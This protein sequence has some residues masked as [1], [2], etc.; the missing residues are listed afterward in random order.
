MLLDLESEA[1]RLHVRPK[2]LA[3]LVAIEAGVLARDLV[4]RRVQVH[5]VN[6]R[7]I[8]PLADLIV[9]VVVGGGDLERP[10][11]KVHLHI[12]IRNDGYP[13]VGHRHEGLLAHQVLVALVVRVHAHGRVAQDGLGPGRG[14]CE[15]VVGAVAIGEAV[16][17]VVE[18]ALLLLGVH[19][20]V[21]H[22]WW[23]G[24]A[25][26]LSVTASRGIPNRHS[27]SAFRIGIQDADCISRLRLVAMR[28]RRF[29]GWETS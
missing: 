21:A 26:R 10:R 14:D 28:A 7:Q 23:G 24:G 12:V 17:E 4:E 19:L 22:L 29:R 5:D 9:V 20:E 6:H 16:L 3:A 15:V 18:L 8:P 25:Q 13:L 2:L 1:L 27:E 11:S